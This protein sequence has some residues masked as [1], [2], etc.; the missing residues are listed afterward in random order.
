MQGGHRVSNIDFLGFSLG[1]MGGDR[2]QE[3]LTP[4][5][6]EV[7]PK[8]WELGC[9]W[10]PFLGIYPEELQEAMPTS[11]VGKTRVSEAWCMGLMMPH[12]LQDVSGPDNLGSDPDLPFPGR[13][14]HGAWCLPLGSMGVKSSRQCERTWEVL[15]SPLLPSSP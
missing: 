11:P 9:T 13:N 12:R 2:A 5:E 6:M 3:S 8:W 1:S 14:Y 7:S 10:Q 4:R 15:V